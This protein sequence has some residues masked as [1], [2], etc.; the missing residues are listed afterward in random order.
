MKLHL[1]FNQ[2]F[3]CHL[4][5]TNYPHTSNLIII[6]IIYS[7]LYNWKR[8]CQKDFLCPA[9]TFYSGITKEME[10]L[11]C[12]I[13]SRGGMVDTGYLFLLTLHMTSLVFF[14]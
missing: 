1:K 11:T 9:S 12:P 8:D 7:E 4:S 10:F 14:P 2:Y 3:D 6:I 13:G 5:A